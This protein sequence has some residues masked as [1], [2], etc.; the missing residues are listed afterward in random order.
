MSLAL[1]VHANCESSEQLYFLYVKLEELLVH[2]DFREVVHVLE[3]S[4]LCRLSRLI[5]NDL[6]LPNFC[7]IYR[8]KGIV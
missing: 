2:D 8:H 5:V 6:L 7:F 4:D 3:L 1:W